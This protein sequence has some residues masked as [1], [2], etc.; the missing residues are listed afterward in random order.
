MQSGGLDVK[1]AVLNAGEALLAGVDHGKI[2]E[3]P[4]L[5]GSKAGQNSSGLV[6]R[7]VPKSRFPMLAADG[8][9]G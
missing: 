6:L 4:P 8:R 2:L 1:L 5:R 9:L 7:R 3:F